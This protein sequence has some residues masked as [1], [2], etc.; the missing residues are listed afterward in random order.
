M[1]YK[2]NGL[3]KDIQEKIKTSKAAGHFVINEMNG[4]EP[5]IHAIEQKQPEHLQAYFHEQIAHHREL[6]AKG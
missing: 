5:D 2:T 1:S 3:P 4:N 6:F